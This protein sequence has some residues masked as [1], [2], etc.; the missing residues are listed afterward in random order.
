MN[1]KKPPM[2]LYAFVRVDGAPAFTAEQLAARDQQ[3][4]E[5]VGPVVRS[6]AECVEDSQSAVDQYVL[7][8]GEKFRPARLAAM[9]K[10]VEDARA[11]LRNI[12]EE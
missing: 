3:W 12:T 6:L 5:L 4:L 9:R 7:K 2:P 11:A 10:M 8:Y 1:I